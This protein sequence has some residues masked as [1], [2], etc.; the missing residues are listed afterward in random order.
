MP[1]LSF[2]RNIKPIFAK[3]AD[4]MKD[5]QV[6]APTG[7]SRLYLNDYDSVKSFYYE[8]QV[9]IHGYDYNRDGTPAVPVEKRLPKRG[10]NP[11][12]FVTSA[13]HP[14]PPND[15]GWPVEL[16]RLP[17]DGIDAFDQW[18]ADGMLP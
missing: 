14:M 3:Y 13:P 4:D 18:V 9:T 8:I 5:V 10:G 16:I 2:E 15:Y 7:T 11:G 12:E 17:Q 6:S 1:P